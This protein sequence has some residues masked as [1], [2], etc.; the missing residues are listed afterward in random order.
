VNSHISAEPARGFA[1]VVG[2]SSSMLV[3][4]DDI[5]VLRFLRASLEA[6][7]AARV[8]AAVD[9][10][11]VTIGVDLADARSRRE[12]RRV[13]RRHITECVALCNR[14][15]RLAHLVFVTGGATDA[16]E[17]HALAVGEEVGRATHA[18]LEQACGASVAVTVVVTNSSDA[19]PLLAA[20]LAQRTRRS[21]RINMAVAL[22]ATEL[23]RD[24]LG[25]AGMNELL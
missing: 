6:D 17:A 2:V 3:T 23:S 7:G 8:R 5:P 13:F 22:T 1:P 24:P 12:I 4:G 10:R 9:A 14:L 11:V 16:E 21:P 20:R 15:P 18:L 25:R 19:P